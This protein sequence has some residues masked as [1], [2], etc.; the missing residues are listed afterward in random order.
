MVLY[1]ESL[2]PAYRLLVD[3]NIINPEHNGD[4]YGKMLGAAAALRKYRRHS[5]VEYFA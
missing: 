3:A 1:Y 5:L 4:T 2:E